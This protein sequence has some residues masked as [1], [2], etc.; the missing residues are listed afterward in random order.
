MIPVAQFLAH[1]MGCTSFLLLLREIP[2]SNKR[3]PFV[4][5][6]KSSRVQLGEGPD[7]GVGRNGTKEPAVSEVEGTQ[8][9]SPG[10]THPGPSGRPTECKYLST[11]DLADRPN[12]VSHPQPPPLCHSSK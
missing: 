11:L 12:S 6:A 1:A 3:S 9:I 5:K 2:G 8:R 10:P 7:L 4:I